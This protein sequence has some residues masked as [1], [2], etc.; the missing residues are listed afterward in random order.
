M[1][2]LAPG[3]CDFPRLLESSSVQ[4]V[5]TPNLEYDLS[6]V[7][8]KNN[9]REEQVADAQI[10]LEPVYFGASL[11]SM[12][13]SSPMAVKTMTSGIMSAVIWERT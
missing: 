10:D 4:P 3:K 6:F 13:A 2:T 9:S 11:A 5:P 8:R 12:A 1:P 7:I